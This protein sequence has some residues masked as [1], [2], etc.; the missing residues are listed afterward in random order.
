[1]TWYKF[2]E[3]W[4]WVGAVGAILVGFLALWLISKTPNKFRRPLLTF[5]V[6]FSGLFYVLEFYLP[7]NSSDGANFL[8]P[9]I[10]SVVSPLNQTL[11]A[12]LLGLG[13][14]SLA[15]MHVRNA[16]QRRE[17]WPYS[18]ALLFGAALMLTFGLF[19]EDGGLPTDNKAAPAWA[20]NGYQWLFYGLYQ[21]LDAT[22]FSLIAFYI[23][24]AAYR[25][26]RIKTMEAALMM[27]AAFAVL[28]AVTAGPLLT[29][30]L[31]SD[32][33]ASN[34]RAENVGVWLLTTVS[35]PALRAIDFG[36][37]LGLL[38]M[39]LRMWLGLER[40]AL[41]GEGAPQ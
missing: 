35:S 4:N 30:G 31:P 15:G 8:T 23:L 40:G 17:N 33:I 16:V 20:V 28:L 9:V 32:G 5:I 2:A 6:F 14:F 26:F 22:M 1:M 18:V 19:V 41:F 3:P 10:S 39:G 21:N 34:L 36:I 13:L 7:A 24:S 11:G 25:A 27:V 38:A 12:I 29:S 37:G